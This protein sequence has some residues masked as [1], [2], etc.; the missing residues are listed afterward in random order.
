MPQIA[1]ENIMFDL[2]G[3]VTNSEKGIVNSY[4][5]ALC[6]LNLTEPEPAKISQYIGRPLHTYFAER[7]LIPNEALS[8]AVQLYR[9]YYSA[10]GIFENTLYDGIEELLVILG[11]SGKK[12]FLVT[13]KP[14][15]FV[16]TI[17]QHFK[18]EKYFRNVYGSDLGTVNSSKQSL[19]NEFLINEKALAEKSLMIGDRK[20]DIHGAKCC[21]VFTAGVTYGFGDEKEIS[22]ANPDIIFRDVLEMIRYFSNKKG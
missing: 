18:I 19:I 11:N 17:L 16:R 2:D 20:E 6:E 15:V 14:E 7:H 13:G 21:G 12:I 8:R 3:T 22:E 9:V 1:I 5:Y 10:K 4:L